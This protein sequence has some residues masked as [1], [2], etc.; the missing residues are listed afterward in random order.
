MIGVFV[1]FWVSPRVNFTRFQ[2]SFT[3]S[4]VDVMGGFNRMDHKKTRI[5]TK[6]AMDNTDQSQE[7]QHCVL[8][9]P[10]SGVLDISYSRL[11]S[12]SCLYTE[13]ANQA[14]QEKGT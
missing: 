7:P 10:I 9:S 11:V 13:Q 2:G 6:T 5:T 8:L 14:N 3:C 4:L 12:A 1:A